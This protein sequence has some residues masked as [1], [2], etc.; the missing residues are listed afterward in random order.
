M[1]EEF[2]DLDFDEIN[3]TR[4]AM[5]DAAFGDIRLLMRQ[6]AEPQRKSNRR[7]ITQPSRQRTKQSIATESTNSR[8]RNGRSNAPTQ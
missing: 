3:A 1:P 4:A 5:L 6:V 8:V 7:I 2:A